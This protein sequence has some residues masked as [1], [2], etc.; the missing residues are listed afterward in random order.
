MTVRGTGFRKLVLLNREG[1]AMTDI[2]ERTPERIVAG[3]AERLRTDGRLLAKVGSLPVLVVWHDGEAFAIE[4]RCPHLGFP[5]RQGTIESGMVTCHWHHARFDLASGCTLDPWADDAIAF[6]VAIEGDEVVVSARPPVPALPRWSG[7]L[8]EGLEQGL[9][10]VVAKSVQSL[11]ELPGGVAEILRVGYDFGIA[12][13]RDGWGSGLT[14]L[15]AMANLLPRLRP[16]D[17][18]LALVHAL[19]FLGGDTRGNAPR[20]ALSPMTDAGQPVER[21]VGWYRRMI[22]TRNGS[23]AERALA[24]A[25]DRNELAAIEEVMFAAACD[26]VFVDEGH[27]LDFTNKAFEALTH[28]PSGSAAL[29]TSL[30]RATARAERSEESSEW[31]HPVDLAALATRTQTELVAILARVPRDDGYDVAGLGQE[32][33]ADD[34]ERVAS[35]LLGAARCGA[36]VEQLARAV[37]L[38]AGLGSQFHLN[39]DPGDWNTVH[40]TF[41]TANAV[42]RTCSSARRTCCRERSCTA[43]R[44]YLDRFLNVPALVSHSRRRARSRALLQCGTSKAPSIERR[45]KRGDSSPPAGSATNSPRA[46][47]HALLQEDAGF[48][49]YQMVEAGIAQAYEWPAGSE[50]SALLLVAVA[51]FLAAHT[52]SRRELQ[53]IATTAVRL[54]RGEELF[55]D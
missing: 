19:E 15:T 49:W 6:D 1:A 38:A 2:E 55:S 31:N 4:D 39:N 9:T 34:P 7:R 29:L 10:L 46:L 51:R 36:G 27:V 21:L 23:G 17:R 42:H 37:A 12:N 20:F 26:H 3:S 45:M 47:G 41:T 25:I 50:E 48:H 18:S 30:V 33:L 8:R 52:P 13:R 28:L 5:L 14:V 35:S 22:E 11:V 16:E 24:T 32:L 43:L 40:H 44:V 53:K 54:R